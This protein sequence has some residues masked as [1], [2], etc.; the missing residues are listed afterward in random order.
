M[1]IRS[2][3][4]RIVPRSMRLSLWNVR[5][6]RQ[7][8]IIDYGLSHKSA[9]F[10]AGS[11]RS[12]TTWIASLINYRGEYRYIF[13]PFNPK[14]TPSCKDFNYYLYL[15]PEDRADKY[16]R[17]ARSLI[18]GRAG[19][20]GPT[21]RYNKR[22]LCGRRLIKEVRAHLWLK[23]LHFQFPGLPIILLMR[24]PCAN[25][26][27]RIKGRLPNFFEDL[28]SQK[29]L[30][31][32]F[33]QPFQREIEQ[34]RSATEWEQR[35]FAW[36]IQHYVPL[37]QFRKGEIHLAF[38]EQFAENPSEELRRMFSFLGR[39][40]DESIFEA[41]KRP[42]PVTR[43]GAAILTG[44]S[45]VARWKNEVPESI[46]RR[47]VQILSIFGLDEIYSEDPMPNAA[48]ALAMLQS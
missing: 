16:F 9:V 28:F 8:I 7:R 39:S 10:L 22:H 14:Y 30:F 37:H 42:S 35:M 34:A 11:G 29:E 12:G 17:Q 25:L 6:F 38:Y 19:Y 2:A 40:F 24:H 48:N 15:R 26:L 33:L 13:E 31:E 32:D 1:N 5:H 4:N 3:Y 21:H 41:L 27:S 36:C 23:W 20:N 43:K 46:V 18:T 47:S 45:L 44:E